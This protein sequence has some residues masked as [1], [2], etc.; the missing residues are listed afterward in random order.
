MYPDQFRRI[1]VLSESTINI[2]F[3]SSKAFSLIWTSSWW[4]SSGRC[5]VRWHKR[6]ELLSLVNRVVSQT[7]SF[8]LSWRWDCTYN[9]MYDCS[10]R[11]TWNYT[12]DMSG[13]CYWTLANS[14]FAN[15]Q[16]LCMSKEEFSEFKE[17]EGWEEDD[18]DDEKISQAFS[19]EGFPELTASWKQLIHEAA[20]QTL[21]SYGDGEE[22][23]G[24]GV[25]SDRSLIEDKAALTR[26][27]RRQQN[28][29]QVRYG[30][31]SIL[32]R[33]MELTEWGPQWEFYQLSF[34]KKKKGS[35]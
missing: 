34:Q 17:N 5:F 14:S 26:L 1:Q 19:N 28:A 3:F 4:T 2:I 33:L 24:E 30:Q 20:R 23:D 11:E 27:S 13:A 29:L 8:I 25:D 18:E 16:V 21:R 6:K 32:Y 31:K 9:G 7:Q 15:L 22:A 10:L 35:Q 12:Q